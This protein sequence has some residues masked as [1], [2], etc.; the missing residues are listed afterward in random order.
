MYEKYLIKIMLEIKGKCNSAL[1]R[2]FWIF[3]CLVQ[4]KTLLPLLDMLALLGSFWVFCAVLLSLH[5]RVLD[6]PW[7]CF[8]WWCCVP[9]LLL[10][11]NDILKKNPKLDQFPGFFPLHHDTGVSSYLFMSA[12][13]SAWYLL[14]FPFLVLF[15]VKILVVVLVRLIGKSTQEPWMSLSR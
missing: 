3:W 7:C 13:L 11:T 12:H 8:P 9:Q 4:K 14:C 2:T 6:V 5:F 10:L 15:S 1:V